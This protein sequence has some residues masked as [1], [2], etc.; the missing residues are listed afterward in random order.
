MMLTEGIAA[1]LVQYVGAHV[2]LGDAI[3]VASIL[4][5]TRLHPNTTNNNEPKV[6]V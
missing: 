6:N 2:G 5:R 4:S 3:S 1:V